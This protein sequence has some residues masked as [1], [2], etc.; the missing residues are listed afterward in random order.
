MAFVF[1][2][3]YAAPHG[4]IAE[5]V[6]ALAKKE[7]VTISL[8]HNG[9]TLTLMADEAD[10]GL[11]SYLEKLAATLPASVFMGTSAH[12]IV[13]GSLPAL[14]Q[15]S[16]RKLPHAVA[17]CTV[18]MKEMFDPS[19]RR[20]Y[21][22]FTS[23]NCCGAQY[24][25][26]ETYP[27]VRENTLMRFFQPCEACKEESRS[28]PFKEAYP[29]IGCHE[30]GIAVR[31]REGET[32]KFANSAAAFKALFE[33]AA[34][35]IGEGK[36]V[37]IKTL[38]GERLFYDAKAVETGNRKR[39]MVLDA[40]KID[41]LCSL[42]EEEVHALLSI[43]RPLVL[44]ALAEETL[45][46]LYGRFAELKYPDEGFSILLAKELLRLGYSHIAYEEKSA[47]EAE[48]TIDFDLPLGYQRETR[49]FINKSV[50]FFVEGE[51]ALF[52]LCLE[53]R[54]DRLA[55][56]HGMAAVPQEND[57]C[58]DRI[59]RFESAEVS[60]VYILEDEVSP[61]D[62]TLQ[63]RYSQ[64]IGS[65]L[66][67]LMEKG[68]EREKAVG[69]YFREEPLFIYHNGKRPI[70]AVPP[71][72]FDPETLRD[73][74][75]TLRE[76]SR[77]LVENFTQRFPENSQSAFNGSQDIFEAAAHIMGLPNPGFESLGA[78][79][80]KFGGKGGVKID[81]SLQTNRFDPCAFIAS[82]MSYTIAGAERPLLA[83]SI[84]ESFGDYVTQTLLELKKRADAEHIVL[85]GE[86]FGNPSLF[87]RVRKNLGKERFLMNEVLPIDRQNALFGALGL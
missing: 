72:D 77:R 51:R 14:A 22:P 47:A 37:R 73:G 23:C 53:R 48:L 18:C 26:F 78:E 32:E 29:L 7:R 31:L 6:E 66:S 67:V 27:F 38:F 84:F 36:R 45:F 28:D 19:S 79:S 41:T 55:I 20:Y 46:D 52:P 65:F 54:S 70:I 49:I 63:V 16:R 15:G 85:C 10:P 61:V 30:C 1:E 25:F 62:H 39:M 17:P 83:Y 57:V 21:Y 81:T 12:K 9:R 75:E 44:A 69:V 8:L 60:A 42:I 74:V 86:A 68:L 33:T 35:A 56:G 5:F 87:S 24:P 11:A 71:V 82:L 4:Y 13:E 64:Q 43:E 58:I 34:A 80:L 40:S 3:E 2:M 59:D 76:G 50:R